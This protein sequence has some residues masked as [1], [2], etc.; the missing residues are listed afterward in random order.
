M[1]RTSWYLRRLRIRISWYLKQ[2][3]PLLYITDYY[4][5]EGHWLCI[6]RMWFGR[7]FN[8]KYYELK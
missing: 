2:L 4:E 5:D 6:W 8:I 7:S 1:I 3:L